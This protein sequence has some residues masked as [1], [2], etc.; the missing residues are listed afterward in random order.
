VTQ[1]KQTILQVK[2]HTPMYQKLKS[3]HSP[4]NMMLSHYASINSSVQLMVKSL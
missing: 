3:M 2:L 1:T 4:Q